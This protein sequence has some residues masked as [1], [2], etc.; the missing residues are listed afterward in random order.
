MSHKL[1]THASKPKIRK[2][3]GRFKNTKMRKKHK[4]DVGMF[5]YRKLYAKITPFE[6][7]VLWVGSLRAQTQQR[8]ILRMKTARP[9]HRWSRFFLTLH[10][11]RKTASSLK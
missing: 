2:E 9:Y 10:V 6:N 3:P 7:V 5:I 8:L 1:T 4:V 11:L